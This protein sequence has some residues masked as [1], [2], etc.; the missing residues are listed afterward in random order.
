MYLENKMLKILVCLLCFYLTGCQMAMDLAP[1]ISRED[2]PEVLLGK[3]KGRPI[4]YDSAII[5]LKRGT[6]YVAYPY[7]RW[8][9]DD[10]NLTWLDQC[11]VS[12]KNRF[13]ASIEEWSTG[14]SAFGGWESEAAVF[15]EAPLK[16]LGYDVVSHQ[17]S[18]FRQQYEKHRSELLLSA[19]I[20]QIKSNI[21]NVFNILYFKDADLVAGNAV[22]SV[23]W[24]VF[25]KLKDKVIATFDTQGMGVVEK[26]TKNGEQLIL[27]RALEDAAD[28]LGRMDDFIRLVRGKSDVRQLLK[29]EKA[30]SSVVIKV[31]TPKTKMIYENSNLLKRSVVQVGESGTGFFISSDGYILTNLKNVGHAETV[32]VTDN[33]GVRQNAKV[34]RPNERLGVVLL[35]MDLENHAFLDITKEELSKDLKEVFTIGNPADYTA[36]S[37]LA[38][39]MVSAWRMKAKKDQHFIQASIPTTQGYAGAP[40][41]DE[42]GH[43]LGIHDG[44]NLNET[45][46][47]YFIPIHDVLRALKIQLT[48]D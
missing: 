5:E 29:K 34:I 27:L 24:E 43:V 16:E 33:Y 12:L 28:N 2:R 13:S 20:K 19:H 44:R 47:S 17:K 9:F 3:N 8:S 7:W 31:K 48:Q 36:R 35:K 4:A 6:P 30:Q 14:E 32:S 46:F 40:L 26:P 21:C 1:V 38:R 18:S 45:T 10:V 37:T 25:D 39:G 11:N 22:I 23:H 15:V 41:M 42:Y